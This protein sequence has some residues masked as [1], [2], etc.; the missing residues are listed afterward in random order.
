ML[1]KIAVIISLFACATGGQREA[2]EANLR[3]QET[4]A[5]VLH[6]PF[7]KIEGVPAFDALGGRYRLV[8]V[9]TKEYCFESTFQSENG[10]ENAVQFF[11]TTVDA[12]G[13]SQVVHHNTALLLGV[14]QGMVSTDNDSAN[15]S[16]KPTNAAAQ[17]IGQDQTTS[18]SVGA[19]GSVNGGGDNESRMTAHAYMT[20]CFP[21]PAA[22]ESLAYLA[23]QRGDIGLM[24]PHP[25][26]A[27]WKLV[28]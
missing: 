22:S 3:E 21:A 7:S 16:G 17:G 28:P 12:A 8:K 5:P 23:V 2:D 4:K 25:L 15:G 13:K 11:M 14:K 24:N 9:D 26:R 18:G 1:R 19:Q 6:Y 20:V 27:V 10:N